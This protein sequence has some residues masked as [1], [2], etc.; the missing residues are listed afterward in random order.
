M[1]RHCGSCRGIMDGRQVEAAQVEVRHRRVSPAGRKVHA[2][3]Q[4]LSAWRASS[5][6]G[7]HST[8]VEE[9]THSSRPGHKRGWMWRADPDHSRWPPSLVLPSWAKGR[10]EGQCSEPSTNG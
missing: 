2:K 4:A 3:E 6:K 10:G 8:E 5:A 9:A 7:K 1:A